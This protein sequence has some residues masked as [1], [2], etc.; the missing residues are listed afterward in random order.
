M[1]QEPLLLPA[2]IAE[3]IAYGKPDA[4]RAE[5]EAAAHAAHAHEFI[6]QLPLRYETMVGEGAA[7][8]SVGEKQRIN[9]ARAF[10]K[11]APVLAFDEPTSGLDSE[12]E[13]LVMQ[14]LHKLIRGRTAVLVAH[15]LTTIRNVD[16]IVVLEGGRVTEIGSPTE[17][18]ARPGYYQRIAKGVEDTL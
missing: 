3:N 13:A 17:L 1:L 9:L 2:T 12:S 10:L 18:I 16:K 14:S 7:R 6:E 15:R 4:A 5:I 8:L 11:D